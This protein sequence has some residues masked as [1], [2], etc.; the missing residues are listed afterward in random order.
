MIEATQKRTIL[1]ALF[2]EPLDL[3]VSQPHQFFISALSVYLVASEA[4]MLAPAPFNWLMAVGA[5]WAYLRGLSSGETTATAW[6]KRL[7]GAAIALLILYGSLWGLRQFG[8]LPKEHAMVEGAWATAGAVVL[9]LIH[10]LSIGSVTFCSAM[11]HRDVTEAARVSKEKVAQAVADRDARN[12]ATEDARKQKYL[13]AQDAIEI[14]TRRQRAALALEEEAARKRMQLAA[15]R[16][17]LRAATRPAQ[18]RAQPKIIY[19]GV[20][21]ASIQ[22][23]AAAHGISRQAMSKRLR[24][25]G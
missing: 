12:R 17:Q 4:A 23:A 18:P 19:D 11:I 7:I 9:T 16:A 25:E 21:Y 13:E 22:E 14:E 5:E 24:K 20:E 2:F 1:D 3:A 15:E 6:N 10:I 8:A